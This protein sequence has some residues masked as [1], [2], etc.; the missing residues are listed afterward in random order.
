M[1]IFQKN[2]ILTVIVIVLMS[3]SVSS[4]NFFKSKL[5]SRDALKK[6]IL[7]L[8]AKTE[9]GLTETDDDKSRMRKLFEDLEALNPTKSSLAS[10]L[11]NAIWDLKYTTSSGILGRGEKTKRVGKILQTINAEKLTAENSETLEYASFLKVPRRVTAELTPVSPSE[12][13]VQ[14][15]WFQVG[16]VWIPAP[17]FMKGALDVT[18]LD[19]DMRLS[20][21]DKGNIFVLTKERPL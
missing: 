8:A 1:K 16:P 19:N 6:E 5:K 9:R 17:S 13:K 10:P 12:V 18:Y 14:F 11:L 21:G 7:S 4:N 2:Y 3:I 15:K 20:R